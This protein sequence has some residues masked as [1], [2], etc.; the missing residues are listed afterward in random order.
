MSV[1]FKGLIFWQFEVFSLL[2]NSTK[3][4]SLN[5]SLVRKLWNFSL[6]SLEVWKNDPIINN[7]MIPL[8]TLIIESTDISWRI[9]RVRKFDQFCG[10]SQTIFKE[11]VFF[12]LLGLPLVQKA[13]IFP[14]TMCK[15]LINLEGTVLGYS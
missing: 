13:N 8:L 7:P 12:W 15:V 9:G 4:T 1:A 3:S 5:L 10:W 14:S 6:V 11:R 2:F